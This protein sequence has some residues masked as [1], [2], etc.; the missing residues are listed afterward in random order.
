MSPTA[1]LAMFGGERAVPRDRSRV[2]WPIVEESDRAG[3][4]RALDSGALVSN[5]EGESEVLGLER[6]FAEHAGVG[7]CAGVANGTVAI[8]LALA[9]LG[10]GAGDEV[11][12]PALTFVGTPLGVVHAMAEPVFVDVD[13][14][15]FNMDP[16][17]A[18]AAIS[19]RTRAIVVVHLHGL[20]AEMRELRELA[21]RHGL[22][23]VED[24]AQAHGATYEGKAAGSLADLGCFSLNATKNLPTCGEGGLVTTDDPELGRG[25]AMRRQFGEDI[26]ESRGRSYTAHVLGWN[27]KL[28]P[29]QAAF[30]R[31]QLQR[32]PDYDRRREENVG[33]LLGRLGDL[34]GITVPSAPPDRTHAFH[35]LRFRLDPAA[36]GLEGTDPGAFRQALHRVLRGEGVPVSRYQ[37]VP[38]PLQDVFLSPDGAGPD[39]SF[40][41]TA[42]AVIEDSLTLQKR[43]L[44]PD[45]GPILDLYAD[46]FEKVWENL[47]AVARIAKSSASR[48]QNGDRAPASVP[49]AAAG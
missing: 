38:L 7:H 16:A 13:P 17:S 45:A 3:M 49:E 27:A 25:V 11:I 42:A 19:P 4:L 35:I 48:S 33:R 30:T 37:L 32:L 44:N 6:E 40:Y 14:V 47:D 29:I 22:A 1:K 20:P 36:A 10:I 9:A 39:P 26:D 31:S 12:V 23:L 28:N 41:A 5:A 2:E 46:G 8:T 15:T 34:P 43:H 18:E 21:D 24:A